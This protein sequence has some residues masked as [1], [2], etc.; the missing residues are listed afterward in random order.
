MIPTAVSAQEHSSAAPFPWFTMAA[1]CQVLE[2]PDR[3]ARSGVPEEGIARF[4]EA[5]FANAGVPDAT[6]ARGDESMDDD[7]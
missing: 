1:N 3:A 2:M 6:H 5:A 4:L 7:N